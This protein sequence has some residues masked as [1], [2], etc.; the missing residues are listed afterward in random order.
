MKNESSYL[1]QDE[2]SRKLKTKIDTLIEMVP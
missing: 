2:V 1:Y